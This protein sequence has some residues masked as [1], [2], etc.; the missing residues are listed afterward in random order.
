VPD[1]VERGPE[2]SRKPASTDQDC[3]H[4]F[5]ATRRCLNQPA[6]YSPLLILLEDLQ[7]A[8]ESTLA[9]IY[10]LN[11]QVSRERILLVGSYRPEAIDQDHPLQTLIHALQKQHPE[12]LLQLPPQTPA[13]GAIMM[14]NMAGDKRVVK[15]LARRLHQETEGTPFY[16]M[17]IVKAPFKRGSITVD[18]GQWLGDLIRISESNMP[19]RITL[20]TV[21]QER[22]QD[23]DGSGQGA[24]CRAEVAWPYRTYCLEPL[25]KQLIEAANR[26]LRVKA[27]MIP[28]PHTRQAFLENL[29]VNRA[30]LDTVKN[31]MGEQIDL[32]IIE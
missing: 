20:N 2:I 30:I 5:N 8:S 26:V 32:I 4:L 16:I 3:S 18:D 13:E 14:E 25:A 27:E 15:R 28:D 10:F 7:W 9:F 23:L 11:R 17:E 29:W 12:R 6:E 19:F 21:I 22:V 24:L 1:L 31:W